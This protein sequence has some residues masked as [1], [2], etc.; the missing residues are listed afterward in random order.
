MIPTLL[1]EIIDEILRDNRLSRG[2]LKRCCL[3]KRAWLEPARKSLYDY[4]DIHAPRMS[5]EEYEGEEDEDEDEELEGFY[6][7]DQRTSRLLATLMWNDALG[8]LV[9]SISIKTWDRWSALPRGRKIWMGFDEVIANFSQLCPE[10]KELGT[11]HSSSSDRA[12]MIV[13]RWPYLEK[14]RLSVLTQDSWKDLPSHHDLKRLDIDDVQFVPA[15]PPATALRLSIVGLRLRYCSENDFATIRP[16]ISRVL[17]DLELPVDL[18]SVLRL[19]DFPR[20]TR[21]RLGPPYVDGS[22]QPN[23]FLE[24]LTSSRSLRTF[25]MDDEVR[26]ALTFSSRDLDWYLPRSCLRVN[27]YDCSSPA[28]VLSTIQRS[29]ISG[30][31]ISELGMK[32]SL[33]DR[34]DEHSQLF[35]VAVKALLEA[36][37]IELIWID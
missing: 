30:H 18:V 14:L 7:L 29:K 28:T 16:S 33:R 11:E 6:R 32:L 37:G 4:L 24:D 26:G 3:V 31:R 1:P 15:Q 13:S 2:D 23:R 34:E 25:E 12:A 22:I 5:S 36:T 27:L 17:R 21:L 8:R 20:V 35:L 10:L 19:S 9:N